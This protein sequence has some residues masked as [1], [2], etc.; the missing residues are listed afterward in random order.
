MQFIVAYNNSDPEEF[1][2]FFEPYRDSI[3]SFY[4]SIPGVFLTHNPANGC[5]AELA[6]QYANT[7]R[8]ME[9][10][11]GR[12]QSV[13]CL[14]AVI[15]PGDLAEFIFKVA[16][17]IAPGRGS[18][19]ERSQCCFADG[20]I[21]YTK[22]LS[23]S[24]YSNFLQYVFVHYKYLSNLA[25]AVRNDGIQSAAG[26][27]E[28]AEAPRRIPRNRIHIKMHRQRWMHLRLSRERRTR[29]LVCDSDQRNGN[30]LQ[31]LWNEALRCLQDELHTAPPDRRIRGQGGYPQ[32]CRQIISDGTNLQNVPRL[33]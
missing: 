7:I 2:R 22:Q 14:N 30:L 13:L 18:G 3:H 17:E 27:T 20:C 9:L 24:R 29:L 16:R 4:F 21:R 33:S 10:I 28:N 25:R 12:Y 5:A 32:D 15:Y 19:I 31:L 8:F 1:L 6:T 26:G 23:R 11:K